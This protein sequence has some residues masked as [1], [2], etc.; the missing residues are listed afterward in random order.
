MRSR[1]YTSTTEPASVFSTGT[2]AARTAFDDSAANTSAKV[3]SATCS[4][5]GNIVAAALSE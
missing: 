3:R 1:S 5:S 4:S 2:T